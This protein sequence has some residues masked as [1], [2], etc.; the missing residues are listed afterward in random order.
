VSGDWSNK[1]N[2]GFI[3]LGL[4]GGWRNNELVGNKNKAFDRLIA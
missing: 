2:G 4:F 3:L 1:A